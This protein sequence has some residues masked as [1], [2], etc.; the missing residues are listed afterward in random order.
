MQ[1]HS[2]TFVCLTTRVNQWYFWGIFQRCCML[3]LS[4]LPGKLTMLRFEPW[5]HRQKANI[6]T[7]WSYTEFKRKIPAYFTQKLRKIIISITFFLSLNTCDE[8]HRWFHLWATSFLPGFWVQMYIWWKLN[9]S[10]SLKFGPN[11]KLKN[12]WEGGGGCCCYYP[13][14]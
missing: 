2:G 5:F 7:T 11:V 10:V 3:G 8:I 14:I 12:K 4:H 9:D 13:E 6:I 1:I